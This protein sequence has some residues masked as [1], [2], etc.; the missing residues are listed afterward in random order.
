MLLKRKQQQRN[1]NATPRTMS[2][3]EEFNT[4][5]WN[6]SFQKYIDG[7][8][9]L[10]NTTDCVLTTP[11]E[12]KIKIYLKLYKG[13]IEMYEQCEGHNWMIVHEKGVVPR[14]YVNCGNGKFELVCPSRW[15]EYRNMLY[16]SIESCIRRVSSELNNLISE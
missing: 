10:T 4:M 2:N 9:E 16:E 12:R 13:R 3:I 8:M 6:P 1:N 15:F 11:S 14:F 5:F 7:E